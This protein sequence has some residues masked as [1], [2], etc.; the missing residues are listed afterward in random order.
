VVDLPAPT[1]CSFP[2]GWNDFVG[3]GEWFALMVTMHDLE[4][5]F[6]NERL[7]MITSLPYRK[8]H[9]YC[10]IASAEVVAFMNREPVA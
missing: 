6:S 8:G 3:F 10:P 1:C 7:L 9:G 4:R 5:G 2:I